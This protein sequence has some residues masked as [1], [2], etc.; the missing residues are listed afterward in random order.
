MNDAFW[1]SQ[2]QDR[3][4]AFVINGN[5]YRTGKPYPEKGYGFNGEHYKIIT[6]AGEVI[7]TCDLWHQGTVPAEYRELLPDNA[8][9]A[10]IINVNTKHTC[11]NCQRELTNWDHCPFTSC[12]N[13]KFETSELI[14]VRSN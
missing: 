12:S 2:L 8:K 13:D 4:N 11:P 6:L 9:F 14:K 3:E 1:N 5:H 10:K 7:D